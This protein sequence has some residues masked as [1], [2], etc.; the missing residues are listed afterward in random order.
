MELQQALRKWY[1]WREV[2]AIQNQM[3][4]GFMFAIIIIKKPLFSSCIYSIQSGLIMNERKR[5]T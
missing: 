4:T 2:T 1:K 3:T 5:Q